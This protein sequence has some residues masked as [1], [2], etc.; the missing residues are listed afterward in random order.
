[1]TISVQ[2]APVITEYGIEKM[3]EYIKNAGFD[4][5]DYGFDGLVTNKTIKEKQDSIAYHKDQLLEYVKQV[6]EATDR[7]GLKIFQAHSPF[8]TQFLLW[9][10]ETNKNMLQAQINCLY[11]CQLL[12][13]PLLVVHPYFYGN[14]NCPTTFEEEYEGNIKLYSALIPHMKATGVKVCLENMWGQA[15]KK[16]YQA[17]CADPNEACMY[18]DKLNEIAGEK[19]FGFCCDTGHMVLV[20]LDLYKSIMTL[21]DR[22]LC[23]HIH[24]NDG[25]NDNHY[26]PGVGTTVWGRFFKA[27]N[28]LG[29]DGNL[30]FET[31]GTQGVLFTDESLMQPSYNLLGAVGKMFMRKIKEYPNK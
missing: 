5:I 24:D 27:L 2:S 11:A 18:I 21:G 25:I 6:K 9:D 12:E 22:I 3:C 23:F 19:I 14:A 4:G 15:G 7:Y 16:I 17:C 10:E 26:I 20:G 31:A 8:P 28:E 29:Y 13:C 1:M 30:D